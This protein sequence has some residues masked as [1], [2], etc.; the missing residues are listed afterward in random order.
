MKTSYSAIETF[1]QCPQKYKFQYIDHLRV[2]KGKEALFGSL[3]HATVK[4]MFERN[5][6]YPTLDEVVASFRAGWPKKE[7][8]AVSGS[9]DPLHNA[10]SEEEEKIMMEEG[11]RMLKK[12]YEKNAPWN[13]NVVDLES[14]FEVALADEKTGSTHVLAGIMDR[15]DK[16][17]DETYEIIDYKTAKRMPPQKAL[18]QNLQ[19]SLYALGLKERWPHINIEDI[20][21]SLYFLKHGEKLSIAANAETVGAIKENILK[22]IRIIEEKMREGKEFEPMP[23]PLCNWCG[24]KPM[25]PAWRHLYR[26]QQDPFTPDEMNPKL[27]EYFALKKSEKQNEKRITE[28]QGDIKRYME[29]EGVTRV[30]GDDGVITKKLI[31]RY[32]YDMEK[33]KAILTP[34][35]K[36]EAILSADEKQLKQL[37]KE[38]PPHIRE[39]IAEARAVAKEYT[40]L[41]ASEKKVS[42]KNEEDS[43]DET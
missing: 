29:Q 10:W 23:S 35:G 36:W 40:V 22:N 12:F 1:L 30:F 16:L 7:Q 15:V 42:L 21:L 17:P 6:L 43:V 34:L 9:D 32:S 27:S 26:K 25:C 41:S 11:I 38:L 5:P 18:E 19:L 13:F 4:F 37:T 28:L 24:F 39:A 31:Q 14:R 33:I 20:K 8:A 2:P 3:I